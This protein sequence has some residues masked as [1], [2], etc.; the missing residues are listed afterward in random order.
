MIQQKLTNPV[1]FFTE[2]SQTNE[3]DN[4]LIMWG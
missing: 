1:F 3:E 2:K 4:F